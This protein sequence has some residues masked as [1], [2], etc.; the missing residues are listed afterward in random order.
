[1]SG[2]LIPF[3]GGVALDLGPWG[4]AYGAPFGGGFDLRLSL[5]V[6]LVGDLGVAPYAAFRAEWFMPLLGSEY[7]TD[8]YKIQVWPPDYLLWGP[9]V[10]LMVKI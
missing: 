8:I 9:S 2:Y 6:Y 7:D 4:T 1:V 5:P 10:G 3:T